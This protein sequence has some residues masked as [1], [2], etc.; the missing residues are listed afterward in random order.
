[1]ANTYFTGN[2]AIPTTAAPVKVATGTSIKTLLQLA[3]PST[4]EAKIIGWGITLDAPASAGI[5]QVELFGTTVAASTGTGVSPQPYEN[6]N[7][8]ASLCVSGAAL[9]CFSPGTEGT[10]ANYRPFDT[11][12]LVPPFVYAFQFP[13]GRE[14]RL[15]VSQFAR[16]R[17]TASVTCN[18]ICWIIHEE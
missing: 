1:M 9:T 5:V 7:G 18:A 12:L 2:F 16:I 14:P 10:V 11:P 3:T 17:V 8:P 4:A 6:P 13:L 15:A